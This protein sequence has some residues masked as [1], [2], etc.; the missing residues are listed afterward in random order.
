MTSVTW[1]CLK[2]RDHESNLEYRNINHIVTTASITWFRTTPATTISC[3]GGEGAEAE[4]AAPALASSCK[5]VEPHS[6]T[7]SQTD[8][9]LVSVSGLVTSDYPD[10]F[11]R[12]IEL[13]HFAVAKK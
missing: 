10:L 1:N 8:Y 13:W 7:L 9:I 6:Q 12:T 4:A 2:D 3:S 5:C 11:A